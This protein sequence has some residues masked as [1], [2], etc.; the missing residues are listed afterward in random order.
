MP[1]LNSE[2][3]ALKIKRKALKLGF[4][5]C[6]ICAAEPVSQ[7][8]EQAF[9]DWLEQGMNGTMGWFERSKKARLNI[10]E[11]FPWAKS[12]IVLRFD[13]PSHYPETSENAILKRI[14]RYALGLDYHDVLKP[15]LQNLQDFVIRLSKRS[16]A[17]KDS[18]HESS[19]ALWYQDTGPILEHSF[20]ER[21]GIGWTGKHSLTLH[22]KAGSFFFL[23][24]IITSLELPPD[25]PKTK[26]CGTCTACIDACPTEAIIEPFRLDARRCISYLT[27]EHKGI[28]ADEFKDKLAGYLFG[29][30][31]CQ[32]VCPYNKRHEEH[33]EPRYPKAN[34]RKPELE[35]L[36]F[37][38]IF[39]LS[40]PRLNNLLE[41]T[42]L[43]RTG[44]AKL[45]RNAAL[46]VGS[47]KILSGYKGVL[48]CLTHPEAFV[49]EA[50]VW[51]LSCFQG[52]QFEK[53]AYQR[54]ASHQK[55][56]S[57]LEVREAIIQA[58]TTFQQN[59]KQ[60]SEI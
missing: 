28:I 30:D 17:E 45:K 22:E 8:E 21:S 58:L 4:Q 5:D 46:L 24:E 29:C 36:S 3:I 34:W 15:I 1:E 56:E 19:Q 43:H 54:L 6:R 33:H 13:Y 32:E 49:R 51:A 37:E 59:E 39:K 50:C 31:I 10:L 18:D 20:A 53:T 26:H 42:P 27:I 44:A 9:V 12:V 41:G 23:A 47:E 52:T 11:R 16:L 7:V 60:E 48:H 25:Q 14:A 38:S 35:N 2:F 55:R 40:D 57:D